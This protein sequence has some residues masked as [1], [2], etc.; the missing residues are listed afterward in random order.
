MFM[1]SLGALQAE[2]EQEELELRLWRLQ[3]LWDPPPCA[4]TVYVG[5]AV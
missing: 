1:G 3:D 5:H 4:G 2:K